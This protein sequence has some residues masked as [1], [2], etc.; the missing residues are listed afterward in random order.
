MKRTILTVV[1]LVA[2]VVS[3][4]AQAVTAPTSASFPYTDAQMLQV[5]GFL[6]E[7][8][9]CASLV[10]GVCTGQ[11]AAPFQTGATIPKANVATLN[12]VDAFGNNRSVALNASPGNGVLA[13]LPAGV[14]FVSTITAI[15]DPT[16]GASGNS[17]R[18]AASNPFFATGVQPAAP[19]NM[20]VKP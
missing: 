5:T 11:A 8:F 20:K 12:P 4:Q 10:A 14:P 16:Q 15:G 3:A 6:I 1:A 19:A 9:Q 17:V 18:S 7:D 2:S 13:S